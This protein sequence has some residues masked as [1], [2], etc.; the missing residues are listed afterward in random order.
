[1]KKWRKHQLFPLIQQK[2]RRTTHYFHILSVVN[3][4]IEEMI[5]ELKNGGKIKIGGLGTIKL[6]EYPAKVSHNVLTGRKQMMKTS[7]RLRM[8]LDKRLLKLIKGG[9]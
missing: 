2:I 1:M 7:K 5:S 3:I 6:N 4:L 8:E 9:I